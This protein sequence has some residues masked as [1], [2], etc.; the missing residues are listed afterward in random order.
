VTKQPTSVRQII[1]GLLALAVLAAIGGAALYGLSKVVTGTM[2]GALAGGVVALLVAV[3]S[4]SFEFQKDR[5]AAIAEK[6]RDVYR[7]LLAPW[8][9]L[10]VDS[11]SGK[12]GDDMLANI[13]LAAMYA[14]C[15]DAVLYGSDAV[16]QRYV[17]F[18]TPD[19]NRDG[20]DT[21]RDLAKLLVAMR[22]DVTGKKS[23][24]SE[25]AVLGT[26]VNFSEEERLLLRLRQHVESSP[27]ARKK[28]AE[29]LASKVPEP[30]P[31]T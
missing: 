28:L 10:L 29:V 12:T 1:I 19:A 2:G 20:L 15:F 11:K 18:R 7:R 3:A 31:K 22:E 21:M 4:K 27:E 17:A 8:E 24:L 14:S 13:D 9:R 23:T 30:E 26:F 6:R 16:V 5:E 25:E